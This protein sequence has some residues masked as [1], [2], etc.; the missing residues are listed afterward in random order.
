MLTAVDPTNR[1]LASWFD[2]VNQPETND[3]AHTAR[4]LREFFE[5]LMEHPQHAVVDLGAGDVALQRTINDVGDLQA[6]LEENLGL[7]SAYF[8]TPRPDDLGILQTIERT[9]FQ[10]KATLLILNTGRADQNRPYG[11]Q[12]AMVTRH[13]VFRAAVDRGAQVVWMPALDSTVR[14]EVEAK[15]LDFGMARMGL[16]R[17]RTLPAGGGLHIDRDQAACR[18]GGRLPG[19]GFRNEMTPP[20]RGFRALLAFR[21]ELA[22]DTRRSGWLTMRMAVSS[23]HSPQRSVYF[24]TYRCDE[25]CAAAVY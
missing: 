16:M 2:N 7:V 6:A 20:R 4:F 10:P 5:F 17:G 18:D 19:G 12:F 9:G 13:S 11:E 15:R 14:D 8:L 1:S 23:K 21:A 24:P 3:G 25:K 22:G